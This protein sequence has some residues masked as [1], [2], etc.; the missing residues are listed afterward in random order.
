MLLS[1][2]RRRGWWE[3]EGGEGGEDGGWKLIKTRRRFGEGWIL[4]STNVDELNYAQ[5]TRHASETIDKRSERY[6]DRSIQSIQKLLKLNLPSSLPPSLARLDS[7]PRP[8]VSSLFRSCSIP[9]PKTKAD[10]NLHAL[11][12]SDMT[13]EQLAHIMGEAGPVQKTRSVK[14]F[15]SPPFPSF[16]FELT[17]F[18]LVLIGCRL[19]FHADTGRAL[20]FGFVDFCSFFLTL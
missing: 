17:F 16:P 5:I 14:S 12:C 9:R 3:K 2:P 15:Q 7:L 8:S 11:F 13:E 19:V 6:V 18:S 4:D 1:V 20:G 10:D